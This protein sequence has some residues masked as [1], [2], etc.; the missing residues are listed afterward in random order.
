M[1]LVFLLLNNKHC[2]SSQKYDSPECQKLFKF[3]RD[4][5]TTT[6]QVSM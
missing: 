5:N 2:F 4:P 3:L 6:F 1:L